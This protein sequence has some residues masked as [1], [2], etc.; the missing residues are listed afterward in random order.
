MK[1]FLYRQKHDGAV[2]KHYNFNSISNLTSDNKKFLPLT[3]CSAGQWQ[4][5]QIVSV[6]RGRGRAWRSGR[7]SGPGSQ[8]GCGGHCSP[9]L[10]LLLVHVHVHDFWLLAWGA[11]S[12]PAPLSVPDSWG[13][14]SPRWGRWRSRQQWWT[15]AEGNWSVWYQHRQMK[16]FQ[17]LAW[18]SSVFANRRS[19]KLL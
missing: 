3:L 8:Y 4:G 7:T 12:P 13:Q 10:D 17:T 11:P 19:C 18:T 14:S 2:R 15:P 5:P 16:P 6:V 9:P 1:E